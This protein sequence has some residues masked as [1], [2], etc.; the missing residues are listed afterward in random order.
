MISLQFPSWVRKKKLPGTR[1]FGILLPLKQR[2]LLVYS[3]REPINKW[4]DWW[5]NW[6]LLPLLIRKWACSVAPF[7]H[8]WHS[9]CC[10]PASWWCWMV[11]I[12]WQGNTYFHVLQPHRAGCFFSTAYC[13]IALL[14]V[15]LS[16]QSWGAEVGINSLHQWL[17]PQQW[18]YHYLIMNWCFLVGSHM[19]V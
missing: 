12:C 16:E 5:W 1:E 9:Y 17:C 6:M 13:F 18:F 14:P 19:L 3:L 11:L 4:N 8:C 2:E 7:A 15:G 10:L